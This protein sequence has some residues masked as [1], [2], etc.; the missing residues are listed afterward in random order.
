MSVALS[1]KRDNILVA[2]EKIFAR[3]G[4]KKT[5]MEEIA[6]A[7]RMGKSTL[8]YYFKS[9]EE[10]YAEVI[11]K[12]SNLLKSKLQ[13]AIDEVQDPREQLG[14][15]ILTRMTY[16][17]N[18]GNYYTTLTDEY[19][20]HYSFVEK[21]RKDYTAYEIQMIS[22]ILKK[23]NQRGIFSVP[24]I[25]MTARMIALA[26]KGMEYPLIIKEKEEELEPTVSLMLDV[27]FYGILTR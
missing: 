6:N 8:Y 25:T 4:I 24:K 12:E 13:E 21:F 23:G 15:Y 17:R 26:L 11:E 9:K 19:L 27:L 22:G 7:A 10:V 5:T 18:L 16:L 1:K 14:A 3:F 20:E 2:A